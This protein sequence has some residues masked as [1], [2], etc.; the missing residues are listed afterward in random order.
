LILLAHCGLAARDVLAELARREGISG[1][2]EKTMRNRQD[3]AS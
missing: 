1:I 3:V 2:E